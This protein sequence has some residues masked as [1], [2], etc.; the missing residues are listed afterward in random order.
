[1]NEDK[2]DKDGDREEYERGREKRKDGEG[3]V[4]NERERETERSRSCSSSA[5]VHRIRLEPRLWGGGCAGEVILVRVSKSECN[6]A[7]TRPLARRTIAALRA[8]V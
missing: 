2:R 3:E 1:M 7:Y 5:H 4:E 8:V 6:N